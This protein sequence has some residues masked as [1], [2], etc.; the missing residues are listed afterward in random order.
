MGY[1]WLDTVV[2]G[3]VS[4]G[5]GDKIYPNWSDLKNA[6]N[7][8]RIAASHKHIPWVAIRSNG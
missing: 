8:D 6:T 5:A 3:S 2:T 7:W 1:S 4:A